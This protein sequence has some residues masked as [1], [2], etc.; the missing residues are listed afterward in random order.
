MEM[1]VFIVMIAATL[2]T[3]LYCIGLQKCTGL[4][5]YIFDT[6]DEKEHP[7]KCLYPLGYGILEKIQFDYNGNYAK[8][9]KRDIAVV[10]GKKYAD[11][12][13]RVN[14]SGTVGAALLVIPLSLLL[15]GL[16]QSPVTIVLFFM[17]EFLAVYYFQMQISDVMKKR[18]M[19]ISRDLPN[20]ISKLTL[21]V[22][23]GMIL[24]EAWIQVSMTGKTTLYEE[25]KRS[26]ENMNNGM[27]EIDAYM[28]FADRCQSNK[29]K[30]F[31]STLEQNVSKGN[32]DLVSYL[33]EQSQIAWSEKKEFVRQQGEKASSK[34]L[35]P[36]GIMF[37]GILIM[38]VVPI[39]ANF[40]F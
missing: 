29:V 13:L 31:V 10:L 37:V 38:I 16:L 34:M 21:L 9:M 22:N 11:F 35:I 32:K 23:A 3:V 25:M 30:K 6:L 12:Y 36:I 40:S 20:I 26:V 27:S 24:R 33:K 19:E 7:F 17:L 5:E 18:E 14:L 4:Y 15:Y 28:E 1:I 39:F 8:K 2:S